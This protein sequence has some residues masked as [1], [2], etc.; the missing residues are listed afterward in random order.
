MSPIDGISDAN[1]IPVIGH[2]RLGKPKAKG[3]GQATEYFELRDEDGCAPV[4]AVYGEKPTKLKIMFPSNTLEDFA[5]QYKKRY[6]QSQSWTCIGTSGRTATGTCRRKVDTSTGDFANADTKQYIL[7]EDLDCL[8]EECPEFMAKP[9]R[10]KNVMHLLVL[11]P[12]VAGF[13]VFQI[14]T[15]S[16]HNMIAVNSYA[17]LLKG[18]FGRCYGIPIEMSRV[19]KEVTPPGQTKKKVLVLQFNITESLTSLAQK[20]LASPFRAL[21]C[22][23]EQDQAPD[24][25]YGAEPEDKGV[26]E[27]AID[28]TATAT[29]TVPPTEPVKK[30]PGRPKKSE[31]PEEKKPEASGAAAWDKDHPSEMW[32]QFK[33]AAS[34]IGY[35]LDKIISVLPKWAEMRTSSNPLLFKEGLV[36]LQNDIKKKADLAAGIKASPP[37]TD[38]FRTGA[39]PTPAAAPVAQVAN[40]PTVT[41]EFT[42]VKDKAKAGGITK[43]DFVKLMNSLPN[44]KDMMYSK[45]VAALDKLVDA[46]LL[47]NSAA[48]AGQDTGLDF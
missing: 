38:E 16:V 35:D 29:A 1:K 37:A 44:A 11:L 42:A 24:D 18:M 45:D 14:N 34:E 6:S 46:K 30:G 48:H 3:P 7:Q 32:E 21:L 27:D 40:K 19:W 8:G 10:C 31:K 15:S 39:V 33:R 25:L 36:A 2:I 17:R 9:A 47:V 4:K 5:S 26:P 12:D 41:P 13:G 23:P 28:T 43:E 22:A 20:Q